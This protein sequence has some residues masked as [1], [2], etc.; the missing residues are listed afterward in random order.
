MT[1]A[2]RRTGNS[3]TF[4]AD[5]NHHYSSLDQQQQHTNQQQQLQHHQQHHQ[6]HLPHQQQYFNQ[7]HYNQQQ[8]NHE[9]QRLLQHE[10]IS[11][12]NTN[13]TQR[14]QHHTQQY[15]NYN[16]TACNSNVTPASTSTSSSTTTTSSAASIMRGEC[17]V[18]LP[19]D[20]LWLPKSAMR[21]VGPDAS[22]TDCILVVGVSRPKLAVVFLTV[23]LISLFLTFH[24]LYDSAVYNIQAAQAVHEHHHNHH[25]LALMSS[26]SIAN[27]GSGGGGGSSSSSG[28]GGGGISMKNINN[29]RANHLPEDYSGIVGGG[30]MPGSSTNNKHMSDISSSNQQISHPMVF[31]SN[32]VH[33]P[34]TSRRLPQALIIGIRKCGTRALLEMLYLHPRIQ[35]AG[36]EVHFFDRDENYMKGLEWYRKKMPHSFRGQIT[37]EKSPSYFVSPEVPERVRAMNASIKLL[38]I[39]RE[40]VTRAISDYTQL[41]SHAA[42]ATLPLANE[43]QQQPQPTIAPSSSSSSSS[44]SSAN[45]GKVSSHSMLYNKLNAGYSSSQVYDNS[46][47]GGG[48][49]RGSGNGNVYGSGAG[50]IKTNF[51]NPYNSHRHYET[52]TASPQTNMANSAAQILS[53]SFEELA[54]FPN[55]TVNES[56]RPLSISMYHLHL[57]RWLEVFPREQILIVNGD[58][59]IDDPVSQLKKIE[60]FLGIEHRITSNH[61]YFNET[62]GFYCL[63]YDSGDRCLRETKG[64]K[65]PHVDPVV[66][67]KL[68]KFFAEH[69]Q[70]FYEL[71]GEDLG[72]PEE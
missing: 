65:H 10:P 70:R 26:N 61:F 71:V 1:T 51:K 66:I 6:H 49:G 8:N 22:H 29:N 69:N 25:R 5:S 60:S 18:K 30:G 57:H 48:G 28:G 39:V 33:F 67:S 55:G 58:R 17:S 44:S 13:T 31:P 50:G 2:K 20:I 41:R 63:R 64:R 32:R 62:K 37:I 42:T 46:L 11:T 19:L 40:P 59:L 7:N 15:P 36:G 43:Q 47:G 53:K 34:K 23:M 68:R 38:L 27:G 4:V 72:W 12:S 54:I 45:A 56:Y 16:A 21:P 24:V 9:N 52:T 14:H 3:A 35:K